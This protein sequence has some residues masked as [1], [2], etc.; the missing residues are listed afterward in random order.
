MS[1]PHLR[2][3]ARQRHEDHRGRHRSSTELGTTSAHDAELVSLRAGQDSPGLSLS[4]SDVDPAWPE[5]QQAV[6]LLNRR[7]LLAGREA[8]ARFRRTGAA[9][10]R[11]APA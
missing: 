3:R 6:N 9:R 1:V 10:A 4:L 8:G 5:R 7:A 2:I 11:L